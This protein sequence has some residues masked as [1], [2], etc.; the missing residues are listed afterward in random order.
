[1]FPSE[2]IVSRIERAEAN[3]IREGIE[4]SSARQANACSFCLDI[5]GGIAGFG[6]A[7]SPLNKVTGI[8]LGRDISEE[9]IA[10]VEEAYHRVECPVQVE[11]STHASPSVGELLTSRG[12]ALKGFECVVGCDPA[13][14]EVGGSESGVTI[15]RLDGDIEEWI[16]VIVEGFLAPDAQ[17]MPTHERFPRDVLERIIRDLAACESKRQYLAMR[18]GV[19][20]GG[21]SVRFD[22]DGVAQFC[23]A[24]TLPEHRRRG[25]QSALIRAR[26]HDAIERGCTIATTTVQARSK[27][28]ENMMRFGFGLLYARAV[29]VREWV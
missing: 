28:M 25:V 12:Y 23:G 20:A 8:G 21:A 3:L 4:A 9:E 7:G 5:G 6:E 2:E 22:R 10:R 14:C 13:R 27:S 17:G 29:L 16:R 18:E 15:E 24:S 26:M 19:A 11:L 1:M